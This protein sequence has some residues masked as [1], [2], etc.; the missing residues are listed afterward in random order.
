MGIPPEVL[1]HV[2]DPFF[3]TKPSG[4]GTGLGLAQVWGIVNQHEGHID[5]TTK[6]G[7]GTTFTLYLPALEVSRP[8]DLEQTVSSLAKGRGETILVVEDNPSVREALVQ[9]LGELE[10][11]PLAAAD[12]SEALDVFERHG[13]EIALVVSDSVMPDLSG[14]A[15]LHG[16]R[17]K[18]YIGPTVL[19]SGHP[20]DEDN[21]LQEQGVVE[22]LRKPVS[23]ERL[24]E[25]LARVLGVDG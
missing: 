20:F 6:A 24:A 13:G 3:T 23:L 17:E 1:P 14:R 5:V 22:R 8:E 16:L 25:V 9:S 19:I 10:Y 7:E 11:R 4:E 2:F 12:G 15:L 21:G 18:G